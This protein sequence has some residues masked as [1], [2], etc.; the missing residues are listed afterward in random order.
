[1]TSWKADEI[2]IL[3]RTAGQG[4]SH[5]HR[6]R[7]TAQAQ[8]AVRRGR[9]GSDRLS[10]QSPRGGARYTVANGHLW[11]LI[12][13]DFPVM[14]RRRLEKAVRL[15]GDQPASRIGWA[16]CQ[17]REGPDAYPLTAVEFTP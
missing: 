16:G 15:M 12:E 13:R 9:E 1:M 8:G 2:G 17:S 10:D 7:A 14:G 4:V 6:A 3:L 5:R 11:I